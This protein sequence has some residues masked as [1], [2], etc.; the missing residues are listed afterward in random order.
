MIDKGADDI[1]Q[2]QNLQGLRSLWFTSKQK[3]GK[4]F[5]LMLMVAALSAAGLSQ[6]G[7]GGLSVVEAGLIRTSLTCCVTTS[8][9]RTRMQEKRRRQIRSRV[10]ECCQK[11]TKR[12][13]RE[14][15]YHAMRSAL[16]QELP[17]NQ[18]QDERGL[19]AVGYVR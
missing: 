9:G 2:R 14:N 16:C 6:R 17:H 11:V 3:C 10:Q 8:A 12:Q 13:R 7:V 18:T 4:S 19:A 5:S 1:R 15:E